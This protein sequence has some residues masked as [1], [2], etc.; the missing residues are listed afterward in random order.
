M[1]QGRALGPCVPSAALCSLTR[2]EFLFDFPTIW[3]GG[4]GVVDN[5]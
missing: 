4:D 1:A 5:I 3:I 2:V